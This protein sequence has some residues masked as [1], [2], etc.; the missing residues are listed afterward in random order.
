MLLVEHEVVIIITIR[1]AAEVDLDEVEAQVLEEEVGILLVVLVE[2]DALA[3]DVAI[4]LTAAGVAASV[5]VDAS[6]QSLAVDM[7]DHAFQSVGETLR[8]DEEVAVLTVASAEIAVVDVDVVIAH[9]LQAFRHHGVGLA[10]DQ[11]FA[12]I[13]AKG[14]P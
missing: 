11:A 9:G 10:L 12:D 3:G 2:S 8:M 6:F 5:A 13:H 1:T 4:E 14:V 7:V